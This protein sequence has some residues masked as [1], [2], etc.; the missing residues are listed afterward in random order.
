MFCAAGQ[1]N[2]GHANMCLNALSEQR[3][4]EG[5]PSLAV[6]WGVIDHVGMADKAI[7]ELMENGLLGATMAQPIDDCL[8][9]LGRLMVSGPLSAA[10]MSSIWQPLD[11]LGK[12][13]G[14][15]STRG[16]LDSILSVMGLS[17]ASVGAADTL[18]RLGID[19]MQM[20]EVRAWPSYR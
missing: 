2:Y 3:R 14:G 12:G 18:S 16:L 8:K 13:S 5:L 9:V 15:S 20:V 1:T 17:P 7:Q 10:V 19:S 4:K 11:I 6:Q